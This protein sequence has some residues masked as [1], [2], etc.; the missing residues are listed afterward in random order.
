MKQTKKKSIYSSWY[1]NRT[2]VFFLLVLS[3]V[4][5]GSVVQGQISVVN[6][7]LYNGAEKTI[8]SWAHP[9]STVQSSAVSEFGNTYYITTSY[10]YGLSSWA[11]TY[12]LELTKTGEFVRFGDTNCNAPGLW[13]CFEGCNMWKSILTELTFDE[14]EKFSKLLNKLISELTC[15]DACF[16]R[17]YY[18]WKDGGYYYQY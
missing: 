8:G 16:G 18:K 6:N 7:Y 3:N 11:C 13:K 14:K 17:L 10:T 2:L 5:P 12:R 9:M 15:I 4:W 1:M